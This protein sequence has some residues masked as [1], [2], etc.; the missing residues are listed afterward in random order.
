M[1]RLKVSGLA[2]ALLAGALGAAM[3][4][5]ASADFTPQPRDIVGGGSDTT[6]FAMNNLAD[7]ALVGGSLATGYN[8]TANSRL[9]SFDAITPDGATHNQITLKAGSAAITRPNGSTEGKNLLHGTG[10]NVNANYARSSSA[11]GSGEV[12]DGLYLVPFAVDGMRLAVRAAGTNAPATITPAQM[13]DIYQGDITNWNQIG[14]ADGVIVPMIPQ[15]GSGTRATFEAQLQASNG[16]VAVVLGGSVVETQEHDPAPIAAD[17]NA[18][19]PF[20]TGRASFAPEISLVTGPGSW[21][22]T[23]A[24]YNAVRSADRTASWFGPLF[25]TAGFVCS[26][27]AKS[28]IAAAGFQQLAGPLDDGV[29]GVATQAATTNFTVAP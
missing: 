10:N 15:P 11:L 24:L 3:A 18:V 25:G 7:G 21:A 17:P 12:T 9:V 16:G 22:F 28:L 19:A 29:C 23:R 26:P 2:A 14:G 27:A 6:Q 1:K 20:S 8:F 5:P 4:S 13:V